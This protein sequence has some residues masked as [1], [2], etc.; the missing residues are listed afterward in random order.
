MTRV[1]T[2]AAGDRINSADVN[3][4]INK[5]QTTNATNVDTDV[6][7]PR[8]F[9]VKN[10]GGTNAT[11]IR[12]AGTAASAAGGGTGYFSYGTYGGGSNVRMPTIAGVKIDVGA[13]LFVRTGAT[14]TI[15][16]PME[17][18]LS[19]IFSLV[20]T[21]VVAFASGVAS[22][23]RPEWWGAK[24]DDS[25]DDGTALQACIT[26]TPAG[27]IMA[28]LDRTYLTTTV[29]TIAK[30]ITI[31]GVGIGG[32]EDAPRYTNGSRIRSTG[33]GID[34]FV[35]NAGARFMDFGVTFRD[36]ALFGCTLDIP[37]GGVRK[38]RYG[39]NV[40]GAAGGGS[41]FN[42]YNLMIYGYATAGVFLTGGTHSHGFF[43][44]KFWTC[45]NGTA[46]TG[47]VIIDNANTLVFSECQSESANGSGYVL[48]QC[49]A[50]KISGG[51]IE[52]NSLHGVNGAGGIAP[53][54]VTIEDID[55]EANNTS[56]AANIRDVNADGNC[57]YWTM[58]NCYFTGANVEFAIN[59]GGGF[60]I[61]ERIETN[62]KSIK[63]LSPTG[64]ISNIFGVASPIFDSGIFSIDVRVEVHGP[65]LDFRRGQ[66]SVTG[67]ANS[68]SV[69]HGLAA[70]PRLVM[71][72]AL[73]AG[74]GKFWYSRNAT[75]VTVN[76]DTQ[77]G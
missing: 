5:I 32:F 54:H 71:V 28:L 16:G 4:I 8:Y 25:T 67:A 68:I 27:A 57:S 19:Q 66:L 70:Q 14:F 75:N 42:Y 53:H 20:G 72:S 74:Q 24:G 43:G 45:G 60:A 2:K 33:V 30:P 6:A 47:N 7:F 69:A 13:K 40:T 63:E 62:S 18:P 44:C 37:T 1:T 34:T 56:L 64:M 35:I 41:R 15:G 58:R 10:Y 46:T 3:A 39:I 73:Q 38:A 51:T 55:F 59:H 77:P 52:S 23:F 65:G 49:V 21:G 48:T 61:I 76:F 12:D 29:L 22:E 50:V 36:F 11:A 31:C 9:H 17:A 26:A